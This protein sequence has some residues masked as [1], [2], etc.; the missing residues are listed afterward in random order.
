[1]IL[2][3]VLGDNWIGDKNFLCENMR[4]SLGCQQLPI[5]TCVVF[6]LKIE[7]LMLLDMI[8]EYLKF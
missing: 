3:E 1:M 2:I 6:L 5:Y 8:K 4:S 7:N